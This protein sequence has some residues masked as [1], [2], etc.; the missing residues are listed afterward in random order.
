[1]H[2]PAAPLALLCTMCCP[3]AAGRYH[4]TAV[5]ACKRTLGCNDHT[6]PQLQASWRPQQLLQL[7]THQRCTVSSLRAISAA[8]AVL[9]STCSGSPQPTTFGTK[10]C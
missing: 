5:N 7:P 2:V 3:V 1:M 8:L 4:P 6:T 10:L 9:L